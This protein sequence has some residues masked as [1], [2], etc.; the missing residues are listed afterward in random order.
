MS[1]KNYDYLYVFDLSILIRGIYE[2]PCNTFSIP[3]Y[4]N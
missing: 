3:S 4:K 2:K 1:I